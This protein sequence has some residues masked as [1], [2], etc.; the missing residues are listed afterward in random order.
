MYVYFSLY[1]TTL[2]C[3][4]ANN[5]PLHLCTLPLSAVQKETDEKGQELKQFPAQPPEDA[6]SS[7]VALIQPSEEEQVVLL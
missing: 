2:R 6:P 4:V 1:N 7:P 3:I 5:T